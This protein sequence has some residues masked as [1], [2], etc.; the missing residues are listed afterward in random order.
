MASTCPLSA[1]DLFAQA[2]REL[3]LLEDKICTSKADAD[4][5][6]TLLATY[7][8]NKLASH[9]RQFSRYAFLAQCQPQTNRLNVMAPAP[10]ADEEDDADDHWEEDEPNPDEQLDDLDP[11][12]EDE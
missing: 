9:N 1:C 12:E 11:E 10:I 2:I 4:A 5:L 8:G 3:P 6:R 7:V